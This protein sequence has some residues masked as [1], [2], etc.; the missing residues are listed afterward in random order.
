MESKKSILFNNLSFWT[1]ISSVFLSLFFFLPYTSIS[2]DASKGFLLSIGTTLSLFF[3]LISR[4]VDG[5]FIIPKDRL[6]LFAGMIPTVFLLSS[7]FSS[8][9]YI[10]LFGGGF[11]VGTFGS[12]LLMFLL[13]FLSAIHFQTKDKIWLFFKSIFIGSIV[14]SVFEIINIVFG[15]ERF[16]PG[17]LKGVSFG[18]LVGNWNNFAIFFGLVSLISVF[19]LEFL[20]TSKIYK[21]FY[22]FLL[23]TSLIFLVIVNMPLVWLLVGLF[24]VIIFVYRISTNHFERSRENEEDRNKK[25][26]FPAMSLVVILLSLTFLIGNNLIGGFVSKYIN[27]PSNDIRPSIVTTSKIAYKAFLSNPVF[28]TG[29]NTFSND[30]SLWKPKDIA[31]TQYWSADFNVGFSTLATLAAT[32]GLLGF[33]VV[34]WFLIAFLFRSIQSLKVALRDPSSNY[35]IIT[36]F[37]ISLYSWIIFVLYNPS[38]V[39]LMLA[40]VS[41]GVLLGILVYKEALPVKSYS[42]LDDPRNSFFSI[43]FIM[44]LMIG[45][46]SLTY[47]YI[48]KFVSVVYFSKSINSGDSLEALGNSEVMLKNAISLDEN[49]LYYRN[50]S[51]VYLA[52]IGFL[53]KDTSISQDLVKTN[54]QQLINFAQES[55]MVATSK[56]SKNYQNYLNLG[57]VYSALVPLQVENSYESANV[58][59]D[60]ASSLAPH[61]PSVSLSRAS[62]EI[63]KGDNDKAREYIKQSLSIK[64]NYTDAIF[65]LAQIEATEGNLNEAIKQAEYASEISPYDSTVFFRLGLLRYNN[66]DYNGAVSAFE[67]SVFLNP[68]Y[69]NARYFL[70]LSYQKVGRGND[71]LTQFKILSQVMPENEELKNAASG[72]LISPEEKPLEED[73]TTKEGVSQ[74]EADKKNN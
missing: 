1:L 46:I 62:L 14:L 66:S 61:N 65:L 26:C 25:V 5:R 7:F 27:I 16:L 17:L 37:I 68:N 29:P 67:Q 2:L 69:L 53:V 3:W 18:N 8:S 28:G 6:I 31:V 64:P 55:A 63:S 54:L 9:L 10:S 71:A 32:V 23:I 52:Q 51:Q 74:K 38:I 72:K 36:T 20:K 39:M 73:E 60:K 57:N 4:L 41:S 44:I 33:L 34:V 13:F 21:I 48:Q 22:Y 30:W 45:S 47:V 49:D 58:A 19:S 59:F 50:L 11:E 56:N 42:F 12:M 43:L 15:F 70:A 24:S 40:F 35:F